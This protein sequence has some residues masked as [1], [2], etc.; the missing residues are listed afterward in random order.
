MWGPR[1]IAKLV[2]ITP[3]TMVYGIYNYSCW[4]ESKPTY[5]W[6][7]SHCTYFRTWTKRLRSPLFLTTFS[8][9]VFCAQHLWDAFD[10]IGVIQ[11]LVGNLKDFVS[12]LKLAKTSFFRKTS[13]GYEEV[14]VD[15][16]WS[17][18]VLILTYWFS[19][20]NDLD[21]GPWVPLFSFAANLQWVLEVSV[22]SW[23]YP[24]LSSH[25]CLGFSIINYKPSSDKGV[26]PYG[27][28][29]MR[30][31][32][33]LA[34]FLGLLQL[35]ICLAQSAVHPSPGAPGWWRVFDLTVV[36]C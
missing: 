33:K 28:Q 7:A 19:E 9:L 5:N 14:I 2:Q 13:G 12:K 4:G 22:L 1:S 10:C 16:Q 11:E 26:P 27:N 25:F 3:I 32:P 6:G 35:E 34:L 15:P 18:W 23:W 30:W 29:G 8:N 24:Q 36:W 31:G 20:S 21:D 17:P